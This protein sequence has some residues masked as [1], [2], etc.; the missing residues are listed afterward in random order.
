[1]TDKI[2]NFNENILS[3]ILIEPLYVSDN[4]I[5][6]YDNIFIVWCRYGEK[7]YSFPIRVNPSS[8]KVSIIDEAN[9]PNLKDIREIIR[10]YIFGRGNV[11]T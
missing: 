11:T 6:I 5:F 10:N 3:G 8:L 1:M 4:M 9:S 7:S 2:I